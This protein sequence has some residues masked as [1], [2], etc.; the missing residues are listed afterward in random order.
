[1]FVVVA[2]TA[3]CGGIVSHVRGGYQRDRAVILNFGENVSFHPYGECGE[4]MEQGWR[5]VGE[6]QWTGPTFLEQPMRDAGI[7]CFER[8]TAVYLFDYDANDTNHIEQ[9]LSLP[10]MRKLYIVCVISD[11]DLAKLR[12]MKPGHVE[13]MLI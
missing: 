6:Y 1:M 7:P 2:L 11:D 8:I 10:E 13:L 5:L 3:V 9:I 4:M 12:N